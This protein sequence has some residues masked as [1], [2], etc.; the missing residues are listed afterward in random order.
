MPIG[1]PFLPVRQMNGMF[2]HP[3][4]PSNACPTLFAFCLRE[5]GKDFSLNASFTA[6]CSGSTKSIHILNR[7]QKMKHEKAKARQSMNP[8]T[9]RGV[10]GVHCIHPGL[11]AGSFGG[12]QRGRP[13]VLISVYLIW[14]PSSGARHLG[15]EREIVG[16]YNFGGS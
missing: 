3:S 2:Q 7:K 5:P 12:R 1:T 11:T 8:A 15:A 9:V 6:H 10:L 14:V 16:K 13:S 4:L